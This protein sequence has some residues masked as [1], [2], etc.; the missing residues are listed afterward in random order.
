MN[1]LAQIKAWVFVAVPLAAVMAVGCTPSAAEYRRSAV[2][3]IQAGNYQAAEAKLEQALAQRPGDGA[4][5]YYM[6]RSRHAQGDYVEA[7]YYYQSAIDAD[8]S[9]QAAKLALADAKR[10][11]GPA[12]R[13]LDIIPPSV[14][15]PAASPPR[16]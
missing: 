5:L 8:P 3:D 15:E 13:Y 14:A 1:L 12:A 7:I 9:L 6:G 10:Q 11:A 2:A 16:R 4:S